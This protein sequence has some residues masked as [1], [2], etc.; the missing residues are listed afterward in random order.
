MAHKLPEFETAN[1]EQGAIVVQEILKLPAPTDIVGSDIL[2]FFGDFIEIDLQAISTMVLNVYGTWVGTQVFEAT[3]DG[4]NWF[5]INAFEKSSSTYVSTFTA[6]GQFYLFPAAFKKVRIR[7]TVYTSGSCTVTYDASNATFQQLVALDNFGRTI[8]RV[9]GVNFSDISQVTEQRLWVDAKIT[10]F[11]AGSIQSWSS[12]LKYLDMNA[13]NGGVARLT[14]ITNTTWV[15]VFS[16]SGSGYLSGFLLN[17]ETFPLWRF[18]IIVDGSDIMI[19]SNG[20]LTDNMTDDNI[21]DLDVDLDVS[22]TSVGMSKGS[23][24]RILFNPPLGTPIY[25]QTSI[26]I[27]LKRDTGAGN[28]KFQAGLIIMSKE[29]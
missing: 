7:N 18:R 20:M 29:T 10:A 25:F 9:S 5:M 23:H 3:V 11:P 6:N 17:V 14:P 21:Y 15:N 22:Q 26:Q 27:Q 13:S 24:D 8:N 16:Y 1:E 2:S 12:K 19:D 28:K 4:T